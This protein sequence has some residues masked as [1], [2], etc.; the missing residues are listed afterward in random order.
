MITRTTVSAIRTLIFVAQNTAEGFLPPR[1]IGDA[2]GESPTYLAKVTRSLVKAGILRAEKGVKGGVWL[3]RPPQQTTLLAIVEACQGAILGD[4]CQE[5]CQPETVCAY[6]LAADEL[7]R[8]IVGVL[9]KWTLQDLLNKPQGNPGRR[10][11]P[12]VIQS[13]DPA[14]LASAAAG[15]RKR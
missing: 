3:G 5:G 1:R 13:F 11:I 10:A 9:G 2:L 4:Y 6:H 14:A 12:C 8:A 15:R 7:R